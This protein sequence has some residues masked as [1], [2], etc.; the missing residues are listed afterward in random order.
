[1]IEKMNKFDSVYRKLIAESS[2]EEEQARIRRI[3]I[4]ARRRMQ[5][6]TVE[7]DGVTGEMTYKEQQRPI[8]EEELVSMLEG[9]DFTFYAANC[10]KKVFDAL[11]DP[12]RIHSRRDAKNHA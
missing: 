9:K 7:L 3:R 10:I 8:T 11:Y 4:E 5:D 12:R 2:F 6:M 1:M